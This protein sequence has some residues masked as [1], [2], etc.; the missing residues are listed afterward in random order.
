MKPRRRES[1]P[2][3]AADSDTSPLLSLVILCYRAGEYV[4]EFVR[5]AEQTLQ[6]GGISDYE[7]ILVGNYVKGCEDATPLV[8]RELAACNP[9]VECSAV[10]KEGWMGWDMRTGLELAR[11][12]YLGV[13]DGDGQMPV[14]DVVSV[15]EKIRKENLD[16]AK[17]F[18][19]TRGDGPRRKVISYG[20]NLVFRLLFPGT[21]VRDINSKPK[22]FTREAY[23]R[24][25][26]TSDDWFIDAEIV[27][28]ARRL[29][30][31]IGE[32]PTGFLG[33]TGRRSFIRAA[34]VLEFLRNLTAYR[35]RAFRREREHGAAR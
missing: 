30:L 3:P 22:I 6:S 7:L 4:H 15:F 28:E 19:T 18:R 25:T 8:V 10:P 14:S 33:L 5:R 17:T 35:V 26:L 1:D 16:L 12:R 24:M 20:F 11:G 23:E 32:V 34:A 13:I 31:R 2:S 29:G 21:T 9:R 27:L